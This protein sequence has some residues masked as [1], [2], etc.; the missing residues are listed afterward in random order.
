MDCC[1]EVAMSEATFLVPEPA[2]AEL[3]TQQ[4][5]DGL[6]RVTP[7]C[8]RA[9]VAERLAAADAL[10]AETYDLGLI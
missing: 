9:D 7:E 3:T 4:A 6:E 2:D 10:S 8:M 1:L 5:G